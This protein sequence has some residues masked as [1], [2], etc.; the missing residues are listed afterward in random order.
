MNSPSGHRAVIV[1]NGSSVDAM[2]PAFWEMS[3][4]LYIGTNRALAMV[5]L[6]G[7]RFDAIVLRDRCPCLWAN[8]DIGWWYERKLWRPYDA[9][10]VG[11]ADRRMVHCDEFVRQV[12]GWQFEEDRDH[13]REAAVMKNGSVVIMACNIAWHWGVREFILTGV[14][15]CGSHAAM[16]DGYELPKGNEWRYEKPVPECIEREFAE[17]RAAIEAGGGT[18]VNCSP[19]TKLRAIEYEP[20]CCESV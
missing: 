10:K 8:P 6:Q 14:D 9:Y 5:A 7:V 16:I 17:M 11:P 19:D 18:V 12:E 20:L 3:D 4:T 13:N 1:A 2:P 15:Y